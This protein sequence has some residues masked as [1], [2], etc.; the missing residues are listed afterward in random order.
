MTLLVLAA[1]IVGFYLDPSRDRFARSN[2]RACKPGASRKARKSVKTRG[3]L[4]REIYR[5]RRPFA[6]SAPHATAD[7]AN[8]SQFGSLPNV[9]IV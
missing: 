1:D 5:R 4:R 9:L 8:E 7:Y 3:R 6:P 2:A